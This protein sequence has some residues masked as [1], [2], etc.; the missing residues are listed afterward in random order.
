MTTARSSRKRCSQAR[1]PVLT[2]N[3]Q[4]TWGWPLS[5]GGTC[6]ST[7]EVDWANYCQIVDNA[8]G[9]AQVDVAPPFAYPRE[10]VQAFCPVDVVSVIRRGLISVR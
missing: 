1:H 4:S 7:G 6:I 3:T 5:S 8:L 9:L 10:D 2:P